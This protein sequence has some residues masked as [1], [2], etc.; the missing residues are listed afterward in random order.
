MPPVAQRVD[1]L[2]VGAG[3]VGL[4]TAY[5]LARRCGGCRVLVVE[6]HPG[7]GHGDT[8][9]SAAAF[10]AFFSDP[11]NMALAASSIAFYRRLQAEGHDL[12]M[13]FTGY[14]FALPE[15]GLERLRGP[16]GLL[17]QRGLGYRVLGAGELEEALGIRARVRG[18]E[19][20]EL[21]GLPDIAEGLLV[22]EAGVM[23]PERLV[24]YYAG[25]AAGEG[26]EFSYRTRVERLLVEAEPG[27]GA[28]GEPY[29]WQRVR[30]AG[31]LLRGGERVEAE[32]TIV[33]A[34]AEAYRL[35]EPVGVHPPGLPQK[36]EVHVLRGPGVAEHLSRDP[37]GRGTP[38]ILLPGGVYIRPVHEEA[39]VWVGAGSRLGRPY[40]WEEE[41]RPER[42]FYEYGVLPVLRAYLPGLAAAE[43]VS[44]WAGFYDI[45]TDA[46]P[47][48][49]REPG[50]VVVGGTSGSG[51]M[52]ADALGRAAA[53]AA[54]GEDTVV[55]HGGE[56]LELEQ[57][58]Y[59]R[60]RRGES[61][62]I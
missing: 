60:R 39:S 4:S 41:P 59:T 14:L 48:V 1:Y 17:R 52:K 44:S 34:G 20:A 43:R 35:L 24:E 29:P 5:H 62:V 30:V 51:I 40:A 37:W 8:G 18:L 38:F 47:V 28:P 57:L 32:A 27:L 33:A 3:V 22:E 7:P 53:A 31:A 58:D 50:L 2:V 12:G 46:T 55:L 11:V 23:R 16:L 13:R 19:E 21:M 6:K 42:G 54:L 36:R 26:V 49:H 10:R 9:R 56:T 61:L 45:S 25:A 15:G